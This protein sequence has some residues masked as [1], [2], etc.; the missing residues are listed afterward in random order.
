M[1]SYSVIIRGGRIIDGLG[2]NK[3]YQADVGIR[4][5]RIYDIGDLSTSRA[6]IEVD[7]ANKYVAPGFIDITNH[8]DTH[9]TIFDVPR[10]DS[11][12]LQGITTI[13]GGNCGSSLAPLISGEEVEA[14]K[15]WV[16][17]SNI[18]ISWQSV[19][20]YLDQV[21]KNKIG[22][23]FGTLVG[24]GT[25]RRG[26][27]R[28]TDKEADATEIEKMRFLFEEAQDAG[29]FGLSTS[30]GRAHEQA[31]GRE[32]LA[33]LAEI[34]V[35]N[36]AL[37]K[38]HLRDEGPNIL[39]ALSEVISLARESGVRTSISHFKIL[40]QSAWPNFNN[41]VVM[42]EQALKDRLA[43]SADISPYIKTGSNL[44]LFL[45][46]W[47]LSGGRGNIIKNITDQAKRQLILKEL[48]KLTLHYDR[49]IISDTL[50]DSTAIGK[51][52]ADI[53]SS[54][55]LAPEEVI[56]E[57]LLVNDLQVTIFN[58]VVHQPHLDALA[59]KFY[60]HFASDGFGLD[61][62]HA[63]Q[64]LPHPRSFGA[65]PKALNYFV[66]SRNHLGWEEAIY[67]MTGFPAQVA[68]IKDRGCIMKNYYADITVFDPASI[69]DK[70]DYSNP[71]QYPSGI[72]WVFVNGQIAVRNGQ[73]TSGLF[74]SILRKH[75]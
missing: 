15:K 36:G 31:A 71:L 45:P 52:L 2:S 9:W 53:A 67:K 73:I 47:A 27:V 59:R 66:R 30:L 41:A 3:L 14:I 49:I 69:S 12:L 64:E 54:T 1:A 24:F 29:A 18:N 43:V 74:G 38:H 39:P 55:G 65:M 19:G 16:D 25:L 44:Y 70:A 22:V 62:S 58:E 34:T 46:D 48:A 57:M 21:E 37:F 32:E 5:D 56:I 20:E 6:E 68:G 4:G 50:R 17:I 8:S 35:Q 63:K 10:L 61:V 13:I 28:K 23:N 72:N 40:G 75:K 11:L 26:A 60:V 33:A 51:T 42:L 7:A